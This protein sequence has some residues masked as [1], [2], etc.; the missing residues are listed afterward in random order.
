MKVN[1][2]TI[3]KT[4]K[5]NAYISLNKLSMNLMKKE[6]YLKPLSDLMKSSHKVNKLKHW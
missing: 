3:K 2:V 4:I 6:N 1:I 5:V